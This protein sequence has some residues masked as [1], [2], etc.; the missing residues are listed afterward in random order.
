MKLNIEIESGSFEKVI[1]EGIS[2]LTKEEV[3]DLIKQAILEAFAKCPDVSSMLITWDRP[4]SW[5][6]ATATLG[7]LAKEALQSIDLGPEVEELKNKMVNALMEHH[8]DIVEEALLKMMVEHIA[9]SGTLCE[10]IEHTVRR[11]I[12][13]MRN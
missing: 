10:S 13:D 7:P 2:S 1:S 4:N 6:S 12:S 9:Y 3:R 8:R 5:S 11:I